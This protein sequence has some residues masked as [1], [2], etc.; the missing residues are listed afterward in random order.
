MHEAFRGELAFQYGSKYHDLCNVVQCYRGF[1]AVN[2][3]LVDREHSLCTD[4]MLLLLVRKKVRKEALNT[5][6]S[7][8]LGKGWRRLVIPQLDIWLSVLPR[9]CQFLSSTAVSE[10][11]RYV[12]DLLRDNR[13]DDF[14]R[15]L[16]ELHRSR[17]IRI[18]QDELTG[19]GSGSRC[20]YCLPEWYGWVCGPWII[21]F[22]K[23]EE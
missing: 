18:L 19:L 4:T 23:N 10:Q 7:F 22:R 20:V 2:V 12:N 1:N 5:V 16:V 21:L 17:H 11:S 3:C 6:L 9:Y 15:H 8:A 14:A 13:D